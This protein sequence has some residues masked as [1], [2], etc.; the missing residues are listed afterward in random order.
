M[1]RREGLTH[2][3]S[4]P[5]LIRVICSPRGFYCFSDGSNLMKLFLPFIMSQYNLRDFLHFL[6]DM[7][8]VKRIN[9]ASKETSKVI[10]IWHSVYLPYIPQISIINKVIRYV[11]TNPRSPSLSRFLSFFK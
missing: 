5:Q 6:F 9:L 11:I 7:K 3:I 10:S 1:M 4:V 2:I 8:I